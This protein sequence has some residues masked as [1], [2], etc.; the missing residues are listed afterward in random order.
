E[1]C[2]MRILLVA[3]TSMELAH[4]LL[5]HPD[6]D[7]LLTGVGV[8]ATLYHLYKRL[9]QIDYDMVI[10]AGIAGAISTTLQLGSVH[11]IYCDVFAD[12]GVNATGG[13]QSIFEMGLSNP[14]TFPFSNGRLINK[15]LHRVNKWKIPVCNAITVNTISDDTHLTKFYGEKYEAELESMEGAALHYVCLQEGVHFLQLRAISNYVGER[16]KVNWQIKEAVSNLS[17]T[18][19]TIYDNIKPEM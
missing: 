10:Q 11:A 16:N 15:N 8:P 3:A 12:I 19:D 9:H 4:F 13:F 18:L 14:A 17:A 2:N 5:R 6:A 1:I 7:I